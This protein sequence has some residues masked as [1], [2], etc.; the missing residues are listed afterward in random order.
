MKKN[1]FQPLS[2][3]LAHFDS[4]NDSLNYTTVFQEKIKRDSPRKLNKKLTSL[5]AA[6]KGMHPVILTVLAALHDLLNNQ[7]TIPHLDQGKLR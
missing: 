4:G 5:Q 3:V 6:H 1:N 7:D 2:D